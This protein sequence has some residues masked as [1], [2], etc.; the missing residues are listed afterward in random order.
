MDSASI[1]LSTAATVAT[2]II[3]VG[4]TLL[5]YFKDNLVVRRTSPTFGI[6]SCLIYLLFTV[7]NSVGAVQGGIIC[8]LHLWIP[9][10]LTTLLGSVY[11]IKC[12]RLYVLS[13]VGYF[14]KME[15]ANF[16]LAILDPMEYVDLSDSEEIPLEYI[17]PRRKKKIVTNFERNIYK[18]PAVGKESRLLKTLFFVA[19]TT[20][21]IL[22]GL[23]ALLSPNADVLCAGLTPQEVFCYAMLLSL[24]A[25]GFG[26]TFFK[27]R[28]HGD[29]YGLKTQLM[30]TAIS[31]C[32]LILIWC[33][34]YA[35]IWFTRRLHFFTFL[36]DWFCTVAFLAPFS[37]DT[38]GTLWEAYRC[39][40]AQ[41]DER[42]ALED[43]MGWG[44]GTGWNA[45][46]S[47][48]NEH[49]SPV[50]SPRNRFLIHHLYFAKEFS[51]DKNELT[52]SCRTELDA[53]NALAQTVMNCWLKYLHTSGEF[54]WSN[55][56]EHAPLLIS[57]TGIEII[58]GNIEK[59][60]RTFKET[61]N[62]GSMAWAG[63]Y[64]AGVYKIVLKD[65]ETSVYEEF[66]KSPQ[67]A[68]LF[69]D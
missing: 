56:D 48:M 49:I 53:N 40:R 66:R 3:L 2:L 4:S 55:L 20:V 50:D 15:A 31:W 43:V 26:F 1:F 46:I 41:L 52:R 19:L 33:A 58:K 29:N 14:Q 59:S 28:G 11:M 18:F 17:K 45:I 67:F 32:F 10:A 27:I 57:I 64:L 63:S 47:F 62:A 7:Y 38:L 65:L 23:T 21:I 39:S 51:T 8:P 42:I 6:S 5:V 13:T 22:V 54:T 37:V 25:F 34:L 12:W 36:M 69:L 24:F 61:G 16:E 68:R 30:R 44:N 9:F 35:A 60:L